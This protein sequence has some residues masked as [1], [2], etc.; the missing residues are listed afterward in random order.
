MPS[1]TA[2]ATAYAFLFMAF[3]PPVKADCTYDIQ[4]LRARVAHFVGMNAESKAKVTAV[5]GMLQRA[6]E[7]RPTSEIECRNRVTQAWRFWRAEPAQDKG[8]PGGMGPDQGGR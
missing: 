1:P 8:K 5:R 7:A 4:D 6:A 2:V 3:L